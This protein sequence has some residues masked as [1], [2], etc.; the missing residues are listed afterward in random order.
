MFFIPFQNTITKFINSTEHLSQVQMYLPFII[1]Q[2]ELQ[3]HRIIHEADIVSLSYVSHV[4]RLIERICNNTMI[5]GKPW[6]QAAALEIDYNG[7]KEIATNIFKQF[8][9]NI[10]LSEAE[11]SF[12]VLY[13]HRLQTTSEGIIINS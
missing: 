7:Y 2:T 12:L 6:F 1:S 4:C 8:F 3:L 10:T 13:F 11:I 5:Q 9:P